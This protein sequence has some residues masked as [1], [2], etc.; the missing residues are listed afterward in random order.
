MPCPADTSALPAPWLGRIADLPKILAE[1]T[2]GQVILLELPA[3]DAEAR[4]IIGIYHELGCRLL[5]HNNLAERS[6]H[7]LV[8]TIEEGRHF[9]TL[10]EEPLENPLNRLIMRGYEIAVALPV[11]L[12]L[13]PPLCLVGWVVQRGQV[14]R[15]AV[16]RARTSR[17]AGRR[18][19]HA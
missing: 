17:T 12:F 8:P 10:Q 18:V 7:P 16:S 13:L 2:V 11:V 1:R 6:S 19:S 3:T 14:P 9:Y 4:S 15:T 5:I